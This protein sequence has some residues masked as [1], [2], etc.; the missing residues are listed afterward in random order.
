MIN[1]KNVIKWKSKSYHDTLWTHELK[2]LDCEFLVN[3]DSQSPLV[4]PHVMAPSAVRE[5][6][7]RLWNLQDLFRT[8]DN[9]NLPL[10]KN[11]LMI[12]K[13][14]HNVTRKKKVFEGKWKNFPTK[15]HHNLQWA[16]MW[17][18]SV[19]AAQYKDFFLDIRWI[20]HLC[21]HTGQT[22]ALKSPERLQPAAA[23]WLLILPLRL[24]CHLQSNEG[25]LSLYA[26]SISSTET[27]I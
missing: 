10:V 22:V 13:K 24:V 3:V 27:F 21:A 20:P 1:W 12:K 8:C 16:F 5:T 15:N 7:D 9:T 17:C 19:V 2:F 18:P 6:S 11:T 26:V 23:V 14:P 25:A 4:S